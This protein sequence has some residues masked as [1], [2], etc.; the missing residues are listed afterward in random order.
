MDGAPQ[1]A[2]LPGGRTVSTTTALA[3]GAVLGVLLTFAVSACAVGPTWIDDMRRVGAQVVDNP[4]IL[5]RPYVF[6]AF[7]GTVT[8]HPAYGYVWW[9]QQSLGG[10]F[11]VTSSWDAEREGTVV[12][13]EMKSDMSGRMQV[14]NYA[15][16][17]RSGEVKTGI[18]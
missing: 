14:G 13:M 7:D 18:S 1:H 16:S 8:E 2:R 12:H 10:V 17:V 9:V 5:D 15:Y 4:A 6:V 11:W 3:V